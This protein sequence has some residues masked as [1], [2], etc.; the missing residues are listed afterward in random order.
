MILYL[1]LL[2]KKGFFEHTQ[3]KRV[4]S[5]DGYED[6]NQLIERGCKITEGEKEKIKESFEIRKGGIVLKE[7]RRISSLLM[8]K[9]IRAITRGGII[10]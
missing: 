8:L 7:Q 3:K 2:G 5:L 10:K 9:P 1:I 4:C 6:I